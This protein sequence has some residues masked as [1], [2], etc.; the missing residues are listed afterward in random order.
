[1]PAPVSSLLWSLSSSIIYTRKV[2]FKINHGIL[3]CSFTLIMKEVQQMQTDPANWIWNYVNYRKG[4]GL[5]KG[6][7]K[8]LIRILSRGL[9][10]VTQI[11]SHY[12]P[13]GKNAGMWSICSC[14]SRVKCKT[15]PTPGDQGI[16]GQ[17]EWLNYNIEKVCRKDIP[18]WKP[19][20]TNTSSQMQCFFFQLQIAP[21]PPTHN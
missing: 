5:F 3:N 11:G 21:M 16:W 10:S 8:R 9:W 18:I 13:E 7:T 4:S 6:N 14:Y 17:C 15:V 20:R 12:L 2:Y 19:S 1:M